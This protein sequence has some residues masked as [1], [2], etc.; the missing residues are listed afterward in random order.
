MRNP[1]DSIAKRLTRLKRFPA[2]GRRDGAPFVLDPR[3]WID[4]RLLSG[5]RY[6]DLQLDFARRQITERGLD[7]VIDI[8]ANFGLY[9]ILLG[10]EQEVAE[11]IAF[12]PVRRNY[13]QLLGNV[14]ANRLDGKVTAHRLGL[15]DKSAKL[16]I[17]IDP[18]ST[19]VS[20]LDLSST[21]RD[22]AVFTESETI[23]IRTFDAVCAPEGRAA[24]VKIDVEGHAPAVVAGM[25]KFLAANRGVLQ[26]EV[27][28]AETAVIE[29]LAAHGWREIASMELDRY[30]AKD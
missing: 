18:T 28:P 15:G 4:N 9:S 8:G 5:I 13:N 14:F 6:E 16:T 22:A 17:H 27:T 19:G 21:D 29:A 26:V 12:E 25:A 2:L 11:V 23:E 10:R 30:F 20:R 7:L 24:F 1:L 3:N